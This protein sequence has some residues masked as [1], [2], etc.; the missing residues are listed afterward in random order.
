ERSLRVLD[1]AVSV[2]EAHSGFD[3]LTE[4]VWRQATT[5]G[6][7]RAVLINIMDKVGAYF[8]YATNT[9]VVRLCSNGHTIELLIG[10]EDNFEGIIDL[11]EMEAHYYLDDLGTKAESREIP[12]EYLEKAEELLTTLIES[13][14]EID[15]DLMMK[16]LE[17]EEISKE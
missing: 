2:L 3:S 8:V 5:Y 10:A 14:A 13:V 4:T 11:I 9:L 17:G 1:G 15:E 16:Y 6:V 12:A 7:P